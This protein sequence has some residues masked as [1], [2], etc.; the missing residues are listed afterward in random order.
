MDLIEKHLPS[1]FYAGL[2]SEERLKMLVKHWRRAIEVNQELEEKLSH[3][4]NCVVSRENGDT[5]DAFKWALQKMEVATDRFIV[6]EKFLMELQSS[7]WKRLFVK[8]YIQKHLE[9]IL[10]H[11]SG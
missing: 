7:F 4:L 3:P 2:S 6:D 8:R 11:F 9:E 10:S 5:I 1:T